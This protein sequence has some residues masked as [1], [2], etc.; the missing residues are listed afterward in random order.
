MSTKTTTVTAP[1]ITSDG[2]ARNDR[3]IRNMIFVGGFFFLFGFVTWINGTLIPYL[4]IACEL[5][6]WESYLVT[7]A[8]Y[9]SYTIMAIPSGKL[10]Q[11]TGMITGMRIGLV[12]MAIGCMLF[13]PAAL[14]RTYQIF[15]L[16][17]FIVGTGLAILQTAVNPYITLL[18]PIESA[19]KRISIM[20][21]CTKFAGVL[22]PFILGAILLN[23][24]DELVE[25][26]KQLSPANKMLRLDILAQTVI[27]P[28]CILSGI[29]LLVAFL[30]K[31]ANLPDIKPVSP[32]KIKA[33]HGLK[34]SFVW[35][36]PHVLLGFV[37]IFCAVGLEVVAGDTIANYGLYHG[38]PLNV[39]K[40]LTSYSLAGG[41]VGYLFGALAI[42]KWVSQEK[43]FLYSNFL[44]LALTALAIL[45]PGIA[46][47]VLIALLNMAN[48]IMWPAVW[49]QALKGLKGR[50]INKGS[51]ILI[52]GIAGGA[53]M[54]LLYAWLSGY[55]NNQV[56]YLIIIPCYLF[57][58]YYWLLGKRR[59]SAADAGTT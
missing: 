29:L 45:V 15:L 26:L 41:I 35:R 51:A 14:T 22:A 46:S 4:R 52:M 19:A 10:L 13:I 55:T 47:L 53:I 21:L 27:L 40:H 59:K 20:G 2:Y 25:E 33:A 38:L 9:I 48:A 56:A 24:A 49:P 18:G 11:S 54:P 50:D 42:P 44:G 57:N 34:E 16:G 32:A 17:L 31:Y 43:T 7:F 36:H 58:L 6:E 12:V 37:A 5:K 3:Y 8:F 30:I 39:A 28:Y 1:D 23:N